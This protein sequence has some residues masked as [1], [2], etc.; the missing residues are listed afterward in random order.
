MGRT[1]GPITEEQCEITSVQ[2]EF[3]SKGVE[4]GNVKRNLERKIHEDGNAG[5]KSEDVDY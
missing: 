3:R 2:G 5:E 4:I 1:Q